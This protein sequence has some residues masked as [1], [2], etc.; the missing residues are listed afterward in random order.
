MDVDLEDV[1]FVVI[2]VNVVAANVVA[3][4]S[5]HQARPTAWGGWGYCDPLCSKA[6]TFGWEGQLKLLEVS[7]IHSVEGRNYLKETIRVPP[8]S[9]AMSGDEESVVAPRVRVFPPRSRS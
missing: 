4:Q 8:P 3:L 7:T 5:Q 2:I 1:M 6:K 9:L